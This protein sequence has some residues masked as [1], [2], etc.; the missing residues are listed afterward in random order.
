MAYTQKITPKHRIRVSSRASMAPREKRMN[1]STSDALRDEAFDAFLDDVAAIGRGEAIAADLAQR[2][3][4]GD[5]PE[6]GAEQLALAKTNAGTLLASRQLEPG[7]MDALERLFHLW[8]WLQQPAAALTAID[9]HGPRLEN[10]LSHAERL[11]AARDRALWRVAAI[12]AAA[13]PHEQLAAAIHHAADAVDA[14][15]A[16]PNQDP[17]ELVNA[18]EHL[19]LRAAQAN[20]PEVFERCARALHAVHIQQPQ[21]KTWRTYDDAALQ[22]RLSEVAELKGDAQGAQQFAH[23]AMQT[24]AKPGADQSVDTDDWLRLAHPIVRLAPDALDLVKQ[25]TQLALGPHASP[26]IKRDLAVK[27]ARIT[28]RALWVQG[29][30]AEALATAREGRFRLTSDDDNQFTAQVMDWLMQ[31]GQPDH[32]AELAKMAL[33]ACWHQR[34]PANR[35][36]I[37]MAKQQLHSET[38]HAGLWTLTLAA[39]AHEADLSANDARELGYDTL[40]AAQLG[41][42]SRARALNPNHP[43]VDVLEALVLVQQKKYTQALPKFER[44]LDAPELANDIIATTLWLTRMRVHGAAQGM[45]QRFLEAGAGHWCYGLGVT[46]SDDIM[47][48][49][50]LTQAQRDSFPIDALH[51]LGT[52]YYERAM[53][54][55]EAFF[56]TGEGNPRDG[57]VHTYSMNCNNLAIRYRDDKQYENALTLHQK[58]LGA[59][60]FAEHKLGAMWCL[61]HLD[62]HAEFVEAAE[63]LWHFANEQ[64]FGRHEPTAYFHHVAWA[65]QFIDRPHEIE[66]WLDRLRHWRNTLDDETR[67]ADGPYMLGCEAGMLDYLYHSK[68]EDALARMR[69]IRPDLMQT[70]RSWGIRRLA[71]GLLEAKQAQEALETYERAV[72]TYRPQEDDA[73]TLTLAREG[74]EKARAAVQAQKPFW[75]RWL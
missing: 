3:D 43:A 69:A 57:D 54:R 20:L 29:K 31:T 41:L 55:F 30:Q 28:A 56:A 45:N 23:Q 64:G 72:A 65:L 12:S 47:D 21:R 14:S 50:A 60:P 18:W 24:L 7:D 35:R 27:L 40:E 62:R 44:L 2:D 46:L 63:Q 38:D 4:D 19:R 32:A 16:V 25:H 10:D 33:E 53:L 26:A 8:M 68:P 49:L 61:Y 52:R 70:G 11:V 36:A 39:A 17:D 67:A 15:K 51:A 1:N 5:D 73:V 75:R 22:L 48:S 58:G 13:L 74:V 37:E 6:L 59:S 42:L 34:E 71:D 66:I 9:A